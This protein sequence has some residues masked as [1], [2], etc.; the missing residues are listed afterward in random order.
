MIVSNRAVVPALE[1]IIGV[2]CSYL[3]LAVDTDRYAP[4]GP[5]AP[6]RTVDVAS[7]DVG[8]RARMRRWCRRWPSDA[9]TTTSTRCEGRGRSLTTSSIGWPRRRCS[10]RAILHRLPHQRRARTGRPDRG[11]GVPDQ[12]V[13]RGALSGDDHA[14]RRAGLRRV[15]R[16][17][18]LAGCDRAHP[19]PAPDIVSVI[20]ELDSDPA[21][22]NR[23]R[24][25]AVSTFLR[26]HDSAHRWREV[27][28]LVGMDE[29]PPTRRARGAPGGLR[30]RRWESAAKS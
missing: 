17:L 8:S 7:G 30:S 4:L 26:R 11:G 25:A 28:A 9:S 16:L 1:R 20:D 22:L 6:V 29:H 2:P 5:D 23:A 15:G 14:R 3:P 18:P 10:A 24:A 13:L 19:S 12:Q 21:R 27:L